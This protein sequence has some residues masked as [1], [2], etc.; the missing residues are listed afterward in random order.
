M[1]TAAGRRCWRCGGQMFWHDAI[2][3]TGERDSGC[4]CVQCG[5]G[6]RPVA[7]DPEVPLRDRVGVGKNKGGRTR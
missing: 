7:P 3:E 6:D 5:A 1:P 2:Y 4:V